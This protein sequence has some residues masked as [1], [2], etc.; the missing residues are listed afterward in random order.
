[1]STTATKTK[2]VPINVSVAPD[3]AEVLDAA[4]WALHMEKRDFLRMVLGDAAEKFSEELAL[5]IDG[6]LD[7]DEESDSE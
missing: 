2:M 5:D 1:M 4:R 6:D 3:V 7:I